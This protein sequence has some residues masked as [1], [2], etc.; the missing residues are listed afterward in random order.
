MKLRSVSLTNVRRFDGQRATIDNISD[1]ITVLA[2]PNESGKSTF[3]DAIQAL[4]F[5]RHSGRSKAVMALQPHSGGA[6]EV[7]V[8]VETAAGRFRIE[9]RWLKRATATVRDAAGRLI[10]QDDETEAWIAN[11]VLGGPG[12][13]SGLLWVKQ[14]L[15]GWEQDG[16]LAAR[17]DLMSSVAGEVDLMTGGR[18]MD[19]VVARVVKELG[20]LA[21]DTQ[22]RPKGPWLQAVA[23]VQALE[24]REA[25]LAIK[26]KALAGA[27]AA[28]RDADRQIR[29]LDDPD[30]QAARNAALAEARSAHQ[31]ARDHAT[32]VEQ[33]AQALALATV[34]QESAVREVAGLAAIADRV[35]LAEATLAAALQAT[36]THRAT[37]QTDR[38]A[39]LA[40]RAAQGIASASTATLRVALQAAQRAQLAV[41]AALQVADLTDRLNRAED[42]RLR[43]ESADATVA[44]LHITDGQVSAAEQ[45]QTTRDTLR[46]QQAAQAVTIRFAYSGPARATE[47]GRAVAEG[48]AL[49]LSTATILDLPGFARMQVDPGARREDGLDARLADAEAALARALADCGAVGLAEA[50]IRLSDA[51]TARDAARQ[52]TELLSSVAPQGIAALKAALVTATT[53]AGAQGAAN[54]QDIGT[55]ETRLHAAETIEA[56][57]RGAADAAQATAI[58]SGQG[59]ARAEAAEEAART[60]L[61]AALAERGVLA[62]FDT[63]LTNAHA[64]LAQA[65][66][67]LGPA[68]DRHAALV[69]AAPDLQTAAARLERAQTALTRAAQERSQIEQHLAELNGQIRAQ[70]DL[71]IEEELEEVRGRLT[72]ARDRAARY[73]A[74]VRA[75]S[76]LKRALDDARV[77]ARDAYFGP[78]VQELRPLL[79]IL[80]PGADLTLDDRTL[81]PASLM[82]GGVN[83][84]LGILSGGTREQIAILTRLAFARLFARRGQQVPIILDDALVHSDDDR[85]EAMFVALHRV[86]QDQQILVFSCRQRAFAA[87]GGSRANLVIG[88]AV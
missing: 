74:E 6:P 27:L 43:K 32:Q 3:F 18:R 51:K 67:T 38:D 19:A 61:D 40:A 10:A 24:A 65:A 20:L 54:P 76:R 23:E 68:R 58:T 7:A 86:A 70:T 14:G 46:I 80:H 59:L 11:L 63:R 83:E 26:A 30:V 42:F 88:P 87:L 78:V 13:P 79:A 66:A 31:T 12:G 75:L 69:A 45:A 50:R 49:H 47:G 1:G 52:A 4:F 82:R 84:D 28:R 53:N 81:L 48:A 44:A 33:T 17:R 72:T 5:E 36:R 35:T 62:L 34:T 21:T 15:T 64:A 22:L 60:A 37:V 85:I 39:E 56:G 2:E 55:L 77:A 9:K 25:D 41:Q 73:D 16:T 8:D 71:G 57:A 29:L